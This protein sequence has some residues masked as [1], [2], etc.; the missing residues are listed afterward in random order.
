MGALVS[1]GTPVTE[2]VLFN[3]G[4]ITTGSNQYVD[5]QDIAINKS[6]EAAEL[7]AVNSIKTRVLRRKNFKCGATFKF[8]GH[9]S[10][11][12]ALF[13]GG[14]STVANG[15]SYTVTDGQQASTTFNL[16]CYAD[17]LTAEAIQFQF[18]NPLF[19]VDNLA[20]GLEAF[21]EHSV[22]VVATDV[23]VF[24]ATAAAS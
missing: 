23:V 9:Q 2:R 1:T 14:S 13:F 8:S 11:L 5:V 18:T 6:F 4:Y 10:Q 15:L 7:K 19:T 20:Q 21:G 24:E 3:T 12:M 16:T 22:T 17:E